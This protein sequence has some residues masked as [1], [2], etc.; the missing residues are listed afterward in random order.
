MNGLLVSVKPG[1]ILY[2]YLLNLLMVVYALL[3]P[4]SNAFAV[5]TGPFL[6]TLFWILEGRVGEKISS[7]RSCRPI[8]LAGALFLL[9]LLSVLWSDDIS[10]GLKIA[11]YY[12]VVFSVLTVFRTSVKPRF[13]KPILYAFLLSMFVSEIFTYGIY[14]GW[15]EIAGAS[16]Q[17]PNPP[18]IHHI[19]YSI[20]LAVTVILLMGQIVDRG[21]DR[22]VRALE[23]LFLFSTSANLFINGGRTGQIALIVSIVT[24]VIVYRGFKPLY[25]AGV[26]LS[27]AILF[28]SAYHL[29]PNFRHRSAQAVEDM[30]KMVERGD[31]N[32]SWGQR[33]AMAIVSV[34]MVS[35]HPILGCGGGDSMDIY[36]E[37]L[38]KDD[39]E[40]YSYT[41]RVPHV[42]NQYLQVAIESGLAGLILLVGFLLS[43]MAAPSA[44]SL[45]RAVLMGVLS[46]FLFGFFT[47]V[48]WHNYTSGLFGFLMGYLLFRSAGGGVNMDDTGGKTV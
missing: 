39:L 46:V 1:S 2:S 33:V 30:E 24:F 14:F 11:K 29:S 17:S 18:Y 32:S 26:F 5:H 47:D 34:R 37:Y 19:L 15:W 28:T 10:R 42:H 6:L 23:L 22:R 36:K 27:L 40:R 4:F 38:K 41:H 3:L 9:I 25:L 7:I 44:D 21:V 45:N 12:F 8:Q 13:V 48:L 43:I 16:P 31:L 35:D 20:F